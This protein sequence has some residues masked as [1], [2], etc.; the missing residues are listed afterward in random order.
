MLRNL[1]ESNRCKLKKFEF[2]KNGPFKYG[3]VGTILSVLE[4][5]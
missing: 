1:E 4:G 2:L 5:E 3:T